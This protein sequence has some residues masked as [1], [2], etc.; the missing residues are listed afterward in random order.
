MLDRLTR[1][2]VKP[3]DSTVLLLPGS[4]EGELKLHLPVMLRA[5]KLIREKAP[6]VK[7]KLVAPNEELAELAKAVSTDCE[8]QIG[9]LSQALA[10]A[11]IA[12]ASTGTVTM[13]CAFFG[14][15]TVTLY[16]KHLLGVALK[17]GL[18]KSKWF[19]MP[20]I[21]AHEEVYPEFLQ[22]AATPENIS[23]AAL[24]LMQNEPRRKAIQTKLAEIV[25][26]LGGPGASVR[27]AKAIVEL[28]EPQIN[29]K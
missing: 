13:E 24:E 21:L 2:D 29:T 26:T 28:L 7:A 15:P 23:K 9:N 1:S 11:H 22:S 4:R 10:L 14:L 20:N 12:I 27:A 19:S 6:N 8:I 3:D 18:I 17:I 5:V 25:S 16:K